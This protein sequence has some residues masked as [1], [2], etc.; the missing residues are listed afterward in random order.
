MHPV[1]RL[2]PEV[3]SEILNASRE[4]AYHNSL[5][6]RRWPWKYTHVCRTWR[7]VTITSPLLWSQI[8]IHIIGNKPA[9]ARDILEVYLRRSGAVPLHI[10]ISWKVVESI[11]THLVI[12]DIIDTLAAESS[13]WR[14]ANL[15]LGRAQLLRFAPIKGSLSLLKHL[16]ILVTEL[17]SDFPVVDLFVGTPRLTSVQISNQALNRFSISWGQLTSVTGQCQSPVDALALL[18][19]SPNLTHCELWVSLREDDSPIPNAPPTRPLRLQHLRKF[20]IRS[21]CSVLNA[22]NL[23]SLEELAVSQINTRTFGPPEPLRLISPLTS[24]LARSG[25]VIKSLSLT[26]VPLYDDELI[27]ILE[28]TP[29]LIHL[30]LDGLVHLRTIFLRRLTYEPAAGTPTLVP[31]LESLHLSIIG[32]RGADDLV[33]FVESRCWEGD[34]GPKGASVTKLKKLNIHTGIRA[35]PDLASRL[36]PSIERGFHLTGG[37]F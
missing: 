32:M 13:R 34:E 35:V 10:H 4:P 14:T 3:L 7:A 8:T 20:H 28:E 29:N 19:Q 1:H 6:T 21:D 36:M 2:P 15:R 25:S 23:P 24:M 9:A 31:Q 27:S 11:D 37:P 33:N 22:L 26:R 18:K 17:P 30:S 5:D 16:N 12:D